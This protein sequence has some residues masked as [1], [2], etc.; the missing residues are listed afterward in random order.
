MGVG[1]LKWVATQVWVNEVG[2]WFLWGCST[3]KREQQVV[4][5][6]QDN[7]VQL[8]IDFTA[9]PSARD[10]RLTRSETASSRHQQVG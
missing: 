7:D 3:S 4:E 1:V 9:T 8:P 6:P 2:L 10:T 5:F